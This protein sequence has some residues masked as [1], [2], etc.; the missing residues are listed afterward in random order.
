MQSEQ[1]D[2]TDFNLADFAF[3]SPEEMKSQL[4]EMEKSMSDLIKLIK[5]KHK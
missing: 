1:F 2:F 3:Q 5:K 4:K